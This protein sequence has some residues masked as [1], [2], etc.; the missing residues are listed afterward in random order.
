[1]SSRGLALP[2]SRFLSFPGAV[3]LV[4]MALFLLLVAYVLT[5][6][7]NF[8]TPVPGGDYLQFYVAARIFREGMQDRLYDFPFQIRFQHD[9]S[10]M[11]FRPLREQIALFIYPPFFVWFCLPF[12]FLSFRAGASAWVLVMSACHLASLL[13]LART[14]AKKTDVFGL[15]LLATI[16]FLPTLMTIMSC[17][18]ATLSFLIMASTYALLRVEKPTCAGLVFALKLFKPQLAILI[19]CAMLWKRQWHFLLGLLIGGVA[20]LG[21]SLGIS[22]WTTAGYLTLGP[23]MSRWIDMP[24]MP[25]TDMACWQGFWR[26][27]LRDRPLHLSQ[28]ATVLSSLITMA[29]IFLVLRGPLNPSSE[30]FARQFAA[31]VL[32][33][34]LISPHLLY[35]DLTLLLLPMILAVFPPPVLDGSPAHDAL[36]LRLTLLLYTAVT[37]SRSLAQLTGIQMITP[38]IL[39][40]LVVLVSYGVARDASSTPSTSS[41]WRSLQVHSSARDSGPR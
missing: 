28:T 1:M 29:P 40:Y 24:G 18:N 10:Q 34:I 17:Q 20:L 14:V 31:L 15:L 13:I 26:L 27:L 12:S 37:V 35:Y 3:A 30:R 19:I 8:N 2:S 16:P 11:P 39:I 4:A 21:A 36:W 33:T 5:W 22:P 9:P 6:S 38:I 32:A 41:N 25:L 7:P 23:A